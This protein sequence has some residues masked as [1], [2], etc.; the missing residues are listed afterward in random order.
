MIVPVGDRRPR[1][2]LS[3]RARRLARTAGAG[4]GADR[5]DGDEIVTHVLELDLTTVSDAANDRTAL[6]AA[7]THSLLAAVRR[8]RPVTDV[9]FAS[10][11]TAVVI[12]RAHDLTRAALAAR[13]AAA[14][15]DPAP[16]APGSDGPPRLAVHDRPVAPG[17]LLSAVGPGPGQLLAVGVGSAQT[18]PHARHTATGLPD[19]TFR[20][21]VL[22]AVGGRTSDLPGT[23]LARIVGALAARFGADLP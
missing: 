18:R 1:H 5:G 21:T 15:R 11:G 23:Q 3:P 4:A 16:A 12:R 22:L 2:S 14:D 9:E 7:I 13:L 6:L 20:P 8:V 17:L 19:I 10:G